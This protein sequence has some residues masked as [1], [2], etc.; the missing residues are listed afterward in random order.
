MSW[1]SLVDTVRA[2]IHA[3]DC[4]ELRGPV[5]LTAPVP[6]T[7]A[8]FSRELAEALKRPAVFAV[9]A[10]A[11]RLAIGEMADAALLGGQRVLPRSLLASSFRFEHPELGGCLR[12]LL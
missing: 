10:F 3:I 9:P 2:L 11:A 6:V 8:E 12:A 1:I 7:N 4:S 5:N